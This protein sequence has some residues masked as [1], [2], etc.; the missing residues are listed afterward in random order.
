MWRISGYGLPEN[1]L[2]LPRQKLHIFLNWLHTLSKKWFT[3]LH[4]LARVWLPERRLLLSRAGQIGFLDCGRLD[5]GEGG[6]M[7]VLRTLLFCGMCCV[8]AQAGTFA[9]FTP[10]R[11]SI[12]GRPV[13]AVVVFT[14]LRGCLTVTLY[15]DERNPTDVS[16]LLVICPSLSADLA[17]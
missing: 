14:T 15:D 3:V 8:W 17:I 6:N 11:S 2:R 5:R 16:Q 4:S 12:S 1:A 13:D 10:P 7:R 9:Y